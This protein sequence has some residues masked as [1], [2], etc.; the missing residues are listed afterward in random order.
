ME[1]TLDKPLIVKYIV[2]KL[3][4]FFYDFEFIVNYNSVF[5]IKIVIFIYT[6]EFL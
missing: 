4:G 6:V 1:L 5:N 2:Q 3:F